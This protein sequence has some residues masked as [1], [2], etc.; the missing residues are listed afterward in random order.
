M[1]G[2][3]QR[4]GLRLSQGEAV[5]VIEAKSGRVKSAKGLTAFVNRVPHARTLVVSS[6]SYPLEDVLCGKVPL[7]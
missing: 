1:E 6:L 5:T 2:G 7:F 3:C 4:G